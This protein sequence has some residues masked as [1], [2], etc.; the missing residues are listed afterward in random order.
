MAKRKVPSQA[1]NG[2]ETFNDFLVGR[3]ITDGSSALTNTVFAL[4]NIIPQ[5]DSKSFSTTPFSEFLTLDSIK[6]VEGIQT[7]T[8]TN[9]KK[10]NEVTFKPN[11]KYADKSLFGSLSSRILVSLTRIINKFPG[12]ISVDAN[13]PIGSSPYSVSGST[14]DDS[15]H[16]TIFYVERSKFFNPFELVLITPNSY[17]KPETENELRNFYSSYTKYVLV[18]NNTP[19]NI[20]EYTEPNTDNVIQFKVYGNPFTGSTYSDDILI[21]PNDGLVE[22]FFLGLDDLE[23]SLLNRETNPIYTSTF[24]VPRDSQDNSKISL[25]DVTTNWPV[26]S[27]GHNIQI[28]GIDYELFVTRLRDIAD[29][30]DDFKSNLMIRFLSS[31]QLFEFD[32]EDKRIESVFQL[33]GQSFDSVKKYIDNIAYMRNV[34]YDSINNLPDVLLKNLSENLGLTTTKLFDEKNLEEILYT[35]INTTYNGVSTGTNLVEAEYEFYRRLLVNLIEIYKS[36]GTRKALEFFLKLKVFW[37]FETM[38][39]RS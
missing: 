29:E 28:T 11:K 16:T 26:S 39:L 20:L 4:D 19:Y 25:T 7:T 10:T 35:R 15:S 12:G 37:K 1:A 23:Q 13:S 6:K 34:S 14:Y 36:K 32:T 31:P 33:Y 2:A 21:R 24:K 3:Q 30:I 9:S 22:E 18:V 17:I 8:K 27:D 5:R 38:N